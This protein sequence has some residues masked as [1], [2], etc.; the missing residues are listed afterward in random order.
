MA[1]RT[2]GSVFAALLLCSTLLLA[3]TT[4]K[5]AG[6]VKDAKT[7]ELL[8]GVNVII[9]GTSLGAATSFDGYYVI[10]NVRPG[11]CNIIVSAIGYTKKTITGVSVSVDLT[12]TVNVE[13][14]QTVLELGQEVVVTAERP[15]IQKDLTSSESRV[16]ADQIKSLPVREV[17]E[18]LQLQA[19]ITQDR[20]GGLHIRG[21]RTGE[22]AYWVDGV[23]VSDVYD[24]GQSVQVDNRSVQ[25]LQV[26][27]G[28]FNAEYGQ[29]MSG[30]VNIVTKDGDQ[31]YRGSVSGYSG[32]YFTGRDD[33]FYNLG[34]IR[35][36]DNRNIEGNLS[37]PIPGISQLTFYGSVRYFKSNGWLYANRLF[38]PDGSLAP[39]VD[40]LRDPSGNYMGLG[41][42]E[43]PVSMNRRERLSGQAKL[44]LQVAS[45]MRLSL[46]G[47]WSR[48]DYR[49]YGHDWRLVPDG[50][51]NKFERGAN[52]S[53]T[54]THTLTPTSFYTMNLSFFLKD[55]KEHLYED[56]FDQRYIVDP[57]AQSR[58]N[59]EFIRRGTNL[60]HFK[61]RTESR[62]AK[63]DY[64]DQVSKLHQLKGG[65]EY[66]LHRLYLEDYSVSPPENP[67]A[68]LAPTIPDLFGPNYQEYT[69]K[70]LEF[71]TYL[72]DKLE[73][74]RMVV[75][76]GVRFDYFNSRG[77]IPTDPQDINIFNPAK[78]GNR[79]DLNGDGVKS[80]RE[81]S[82]PVVVASRKAYWYRNA[83]AKYTFS[84][85][86]GVSYPI[87]DRGA[88]HFSYGHF[89]QI[90]SFERLFQRPGFKIQPTVTGIQGVFG[91]PDLN[92]QR[93]VQYEFGLQQ[94][95]TDV[96]TF[97]V[98][99]FYRDI[100]DWVTTSAP[101]P[102]RDPTSLTATTHYTMFVNRD[103]ANA[104]GITFK[105]DKRMRDMFSVNLSY[106]FQIAE[107]NNSNPDEEQGALTGN[108]EPARFLAPLEWDQ[109]HTANLSVGLGQEDWG[110]FVL[111]RYGSGLPYSPV[112]NQAEARGE[113]AARAVTKNSRRRPA[114]YTIDLQLFK[115][116]N[117][118]G[119]TNLQVFMKVFNLFDQRNELEVFGE[120]GR[121]SATPQALGVPGGSTPDRVHT[122]EEY[123]VRPDF[124][125]EPREIQLGLEINF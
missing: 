64:T 84:P 97:D 114:T 53:A 43:N 110:A 46:A 55:F 27:S 22:V 1:H 96:L 10:L 117:L 26:I 9:E 63:L 93:T 90:P 59:R 39:G 73:Y 78:D 20:F 60:H 34:K 56:P 86:I 124:F 85:R 44:T 13:L 92:P 8:V 19:G 123:L 58:G 91:N 98:T 120:T 121:A 82:D 77:Q 54:W 68:P 7:G 35:P 81:Q 18:V 79:V 41:R 17:R 33:I 49:D 115:N 69:E 30:I 11:P 14:D 3:G 2:L 45:Q 74:D 31:E 108:R 104:R 42:G 57:Q 113:D 62:V 83:S 23:S 103:Y 105:L 125:S 87:T 67:L 111:A 32:G 70:P 28:T 119:S 75:N 52:Y 109:T 112:I 122:I 66:R 24:G 48:I 71:S 51:V 101:I 37:G 16:S 5:I 95:L 4:G 88:L 61:R 50:D 29:A 25:E 72:Q 116:F 21:G 106:T 40:T 99:A 38:D 118:A 36:L 100:R 107:G 94:A 15:A 102:L 76:V 89:L 80:D 65:L 6:E 47:L 12:T